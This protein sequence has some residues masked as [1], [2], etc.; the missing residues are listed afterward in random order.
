[1]AA[2]DPKRTSKSSSNP[3]DKQQAL[4]RFNLHGGVII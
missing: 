2:V 3:C 1:M 4:L